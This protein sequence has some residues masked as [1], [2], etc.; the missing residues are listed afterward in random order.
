MLDASQGNTQQAS[1]EFR[2]VL[3]SPDT[4]MTYH[5]TRL[6]MSGNNP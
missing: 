4:L 3:L 2:E 5:L 1:K 6:A